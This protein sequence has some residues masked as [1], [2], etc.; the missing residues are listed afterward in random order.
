MQT[1]YVSEFFPESHE[2][3]AWQLSDER[4]KRPQRAKT[5]VLQAYLLKFMTRVSLKD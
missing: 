3:Q 5:R 1:E 4:P 2:G